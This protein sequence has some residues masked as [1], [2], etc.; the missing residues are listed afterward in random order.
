MLTNTL[1]A[2]PNQLENLKGLE[3]HNSINILDLNALRK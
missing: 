1:T 2:Y 3:E